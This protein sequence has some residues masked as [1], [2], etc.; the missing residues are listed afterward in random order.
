MGARKLSPWR[1]PASALLLCP[2]TAVRLVE[3][4]FTDGADRHVGP[5]EVKQDTPARS[6]CPPRPRTA[7]SPRWRPT[8]S[9]HGGQPVPISRLMLHHIVFA[10]D[11]QGRRDLHQLPGFDSR[12][13]PA[14]PRQRFYAAGE[15]RAKVSLPPGYGYPIE[16]PSTGEQPLWG[17]TYMVMNHRDVPDNAL[18]QYTVTYET[19]PVGTGMKAVKPYWLDVRDCKADP[20]YNVPG[21]AKAAKKAKGK[22]NKGKKGA[23]GAK[24]KKQEAQ[25]KEEA[26]GSAHRRRDPRLHDPRGRA[27]R[28]GR[29]PRPRRRI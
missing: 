1:G 17:M 8:S 14:S 23:S 18:I 4:T 13:G 24:G 27:D 12:P 7:T 6:P 28:R 15:E 16:G 5:Y 19:D 9:T 3:Q 22:K 26:G 25:E 2:Q 20:I 11:P 10:N 29:R 21:V